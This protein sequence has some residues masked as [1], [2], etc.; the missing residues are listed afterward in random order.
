MAVLIK[1]IIF[2]SIRKQLTPM[3][4]NFAKVITSEPQTYNAA[5]QVRLIRTAL[6]YLIDPKLPTKRMLITLPVWF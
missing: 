2:R 4:V 1:Q 3:Q 5:R 6:F